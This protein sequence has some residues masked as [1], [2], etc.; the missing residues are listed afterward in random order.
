MTSTFLIILL[1]RNRFLFI[2]P[3]IIVIIFFHIQIQWAATVNSEYI[4]SYLFDPIVFAI[5][6]HGFPL[7]GL[8]ISFITMRNSALVVWHRITNYSQNYIYR[9]S[10]R[11]IFLLFACVLFV[12]LW[13]LSYVP[14]SK[15]GLFS[16]F[17]DPMS[18]DQAREESLKLIPNV[19]LKYAFTF[20]Q[21][22]FS[23]LLAVLTTLFIVY[24]FKRKFMV[25]VAFGIILLFG[26]LIS[27]SLPGARAPAAVVILSIIWAFFL[28]KGMAI[29]PLQII[30]AFVVVLL[31]PIMLTILGSGHEIS[32][33]IFLQ[34][35][36]DSI[37]YR[38][39]ADP[40]ITALW[41][42]QYVQQSGYFGIA[43]IPKL[44]YLCGLDPINVANLIHL[45]HF[46][47]A[48]TSGLSNTCYVFSYYSYFGFSSIVFS[49]FGLWFLDLSVLVYKKLN[50][51]ILLSCV[52]A[53][54]V[55]CISFVSAD[56]T[57]VILTFGFFPILIVSMAL[58][59]CCRIKVEKF[60]KSKH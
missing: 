25:H 54:S 10:N 4:E 26:V 46:P 44:A 12:T 6:A 21:S 1:W 16:I 36:T 32:F 57:T 22:T 24:S 13:Y 43:A 31:V 23:P 53:V 29:Q 40:M 15:T 60:L 52:S 27:V 58:D 59:Y 18:S 33:S 34:Y 55:A 49:L 37:F 7:I 38:V 28:K 9:K 2:K 41:H 35:L 3:S 48:A 11:A 42:I 8:F 47:D 14:I 30:I 50:D 19:Q 39:F 45:E 17:F 51:F 56:Y 5:L 20:L